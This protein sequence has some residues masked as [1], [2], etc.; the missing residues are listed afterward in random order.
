VANLI[1]GLDEAEETVLLARARSGPREK[2]LVAGELYRLFRKPVLNLCLN[3]AGTRSDAEDA[4]QE[5][6]VSVYRA[7]HLFRGE[8]RV[9]TWIF[10][11]A[12]RTSIELRAKHRPSVPLDPDLPAE[13]GNESDL[14]ARDEVRR[15]V[16]A[17]GRLPSD[18]RTVL[19]LFALDGLAHREIADILGISEGTV[20]S[21]LNTAR[22]ALAE[23]LGRVRPRER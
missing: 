13:R 6:F 2:E 9:R 16:A 17:M 18:Q 1:G 11:I 12:I 5:T 3:V 15:M 10:R 4:A 7:L 8:S 22:R 21:R 20:W 14:V 19:A 23:E